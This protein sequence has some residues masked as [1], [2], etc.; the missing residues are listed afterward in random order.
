MKS[1]INRVLVAGI[2]F[3]FIITG[4]GPVT[5]KQIR[6]HDNARQLT[7]AQILKLVDGNTLLF[8]SFDE[9]SYYFFDHSGRVFGADMQ[10]NKDTGRWD[11]SD[12]AELCMKLNTWWYGYP[13]CFQV[14]SDRNN[15]RLANK[16]GLIIFTA[17]RH[18]GD[19]KNLYHEIKTAKK[20]QR[21]SIRHRATGQAASKQ[22][23]STRGNAAATTSR[24]A[25]VEGNAYQAAPRESDMKPTIK[26]L[27]K[28]CPD[29][30]LAKSD[31]RNADLIMANL[32]GADLNGADLS[33]AN[34]RRANLQGANL[35]NA[36]LTYANMPGANLKNCN[37]RGAD[38]KGAD[39]IRADLT[40]ADL[41]GADLSGAN[42]DGALL[43]RVLG[44]NK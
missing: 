43:D 42:L 25:I 41:S 26:W 37:L 44:L 24:K 5:V 6:E 13:R 22:T 31:L 20:Y 10:N 7:A 16:D 35:E 8:E 33:R 15:Y 36:N 18:K 11:V 1:N 40:G 2:F 38:L 28:D 12:K 30:N 19:F 29:C 27:A 23:M 17:T 9:N 14:Y 34:L 39:L 32:R 21:R 3:C 4:C